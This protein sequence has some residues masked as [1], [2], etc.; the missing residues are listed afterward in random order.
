MSSVHERLREKARSLAGLPRIFQL[1]WQAHPPLCAA[2][3]LLN[4]LQGMVPVAQAWLSKLVIDLI[5]A[6]IAGQPV[7]TAGVLRLVAVSAGIALASTCI[8]PTATFIQVQL[9][10]YLKRQVQLLI[11]RK[12]N[13]L[14]DISYFEDP[15]YYD[16]LQRAQGDA[17]YRPLNVLYYAV[18]LFRNLVYAA[19]T[20]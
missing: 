7:G 5:G 20:D 17:G 15:A 16:R 3:A 9:G 2:L 8:E 11:L 13:S 10:D 19:L 12:T 4:L 1:V 18:Q 6:S 14:A